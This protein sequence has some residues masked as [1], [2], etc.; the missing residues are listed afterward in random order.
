MNHC[1]VFQLNVL[2]TGA[3]CKF[4]LTWGE[5][6]QLSAS[7]KYPV[8]LDTLYEAW[9]NSYLR[10]YPWR[11]RGRREEDFSFT[12]SSV[13]WKNQSEQAKRVFL[14]KFQQWLGGS[15]LLEIRHRIQSEI[16][17]KTS[18][19]KLR[20]GS[21]NCV[22]LLV[23]CDS[24]EL[25]RLPWEAWEIVPKD[26]PLAAAI[27]ISRTPIIAGNKAI[28]V[29][30][31]PRR[32]KA[33]ILMILAAT[34]E[35]NL[36]SDQSAVELLSQSKAAEIYPLQFKSGENADDCKKKFIGQLVDDRGWDALI[37][38]GHS[39][40]TPLTGGRLELAPSVFLSIS[41]IDQQLI[42]A[43]NQGLRVAIFNSCTG[44]SFADYLIKL[45]LSQV[46][47][48]RE[49]IH[50]QVA[51]IFLK[52]FC[53]SLAAHKDIQEAILEACQ[54]LESEKNAY[55][56]AYLIPSLFRHPSPKVK[57]F[58]IEPLGWRRFW[59]DWKPSRGEAIAFGIALFVSL[60]VPVQDLLFDSRTL[61]QAVYRDLTQELP[62]GTPPVRLI[63]IDQ[64]S[65]TQASGKLERFQIWPM[66]RQYLAQ[67]VS[68]ISD[69][70]VRTIGINYLLATEEPKGYQLTESIESAVRQQSTWFVFA[71]D[72]QK[73][74]KVF[75]KIADPKWSFQG[76][77]S[78]LP[79]DVELPA[80]ETCVKSCPF[81]YLLALS[82][83]L[84][85]EQS[86]ASLPQP[87]LQSQTD[88]QEEVSNYLKQG[89]GESKAIALLKQAYSP[90]GLRSV[91]DFSIPPKQVYERIPAW[92]FLKLGSPN[93]ELQERIEQQVAIVTYGGYEGAF[94][95]LLSSFGY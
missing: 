48:M 53:Q 2:R 83:L 73:K 93:P 19:K 50:D 10:A 20:M 4:L 41:E 26:S 1:S 72:E 16:V 88:F 63:A 70:N 9:Q 13:D 92:E 86:V 66:D 82:H 84:N 25:V 46:V 80:D 52:Q 8:E 71:V 61:V 94:D 62:Q 57:L 22:D 51:S 3:N 55:P 76:N 7:L 35:L 32:G 34:P 18:E 56:S 5:R 67:L 14:Q 23:A 64:E 77:T 24:P 45:G 49:K 36:D 75:P 89:N 87:K 30:N 6:E 11:P 38:A 31:T 81:A 68:R 65:I 60:I 74:L 42:Q 27:R 85:R 15:E 43:K 28:C 54:Y 58:R 21:D 90:F 44:L 69:L 40:E 33:R 12:P 17:C 39:D 37:F 95:G 91:I 29:E 47:V 79:W 59:R 78:F